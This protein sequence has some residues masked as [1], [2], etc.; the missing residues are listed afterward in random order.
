MKY[1]IAARTEFGVGGWTCPCGAFEVW[2]VAAEVDA[3]LVL[4]CPSCGQRSEVVAMDLVG[5]GA[6]EDEG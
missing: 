4:V 3:S 2:G 1:E 5:E 6:E